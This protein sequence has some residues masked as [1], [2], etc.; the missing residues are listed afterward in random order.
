MH[1]ITFKKII[2][3]HILAGALLVAG[4]ASAA[5]F[6]LGDTVPSEVQTGQT[7]YVPV[8]VYPEYPG[9]EIS[10]AGISLSFSKKTLWLHSFTL[11]PEWTRVSDERT[12]SLSNERGTFVTAAGL[13]TQVT[14]P[15][16]LGVLEFIATNEG[17][18]TVL[19]ENSSYIFGKNNR[20]I[21]TDGWLPQASL[22][23]TRGVGILPEQLFDIALAAGKNQY[24]YGETPSL[25]LSFQSFGSVPTP[26]DIE[27]RVVSE[28]GEVVFE[29]K[30][31][32]VVE[33]EFAYV[34]KVAVPKLPSGYYITIVTTHYNG[35]VTDSWRDTFT[36]LPHVT[37]Y[38]VYG[39]AGVALVI[40]IATIWFSLR[41]K[42][43]KVAF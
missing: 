37:P 42:S 5:V 12:T 15:T 23:V 36:V 11:A 29:W 16:Y 28:K 26:V 22:T 27:G 8:Y 33:T 19:F 24:K 38:Y 25:R 20:S 14:E 40:G 41:R 1:H 6:R 3:S 35:D 13:R 18:A 31:A 9:E 34:K 4:S 7:V 39:S 21:L 30:D 32:I 2:A 10:V 17:L 43:R